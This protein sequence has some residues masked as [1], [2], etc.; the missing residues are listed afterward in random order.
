MATGLLEIQK[1]KKPFSFSRAL[2]I[3]SNGL[4][5]DKK[6]AYEKQ[7]HT[8]IRDRR[9]VVEHQNLSRTVSLG[10]PIKSRRR[11]RWGGN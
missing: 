5:I 6:K 2:E 8:E 9:S 10:E 4:R 11:Y 7:Q 3:T 1:K